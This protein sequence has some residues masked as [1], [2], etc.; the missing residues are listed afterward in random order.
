MLTSTSISA[1]LPPLRSKRKLKPKAPN[2]AVILD[3]HIQTE[4]PEPPPP[5]PSKIKRVR[6]IVRRPPLPLTN[7]RQR[8]SQPKF[9]WSLNNFLSS[10]TWFGEDELDLDLATLEQNAGADAE[11]LE[12]VEQFRRE[13]RFLPGTQT[14]FGTKHDDTE[15]HPPQRNSTDVWDDVVKAVVARSRPKK[16]LGRQIT[17]QI[18][19]KIQTYFDIRESRRIKAEGAEERRLRNLAKSTMKLVVG[20]WKKAIF[21]SFYF[22][23]KFVV[24]VA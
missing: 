9:K 19:S 6:L 21:V 18:A 3:T 2:T 1:P 16:P 23:D 15:Y 5:S 24:W 10:Y 14:L 11:I 22:S 12:R 7:P 20:E 4:P 17:S 8:P 13:G